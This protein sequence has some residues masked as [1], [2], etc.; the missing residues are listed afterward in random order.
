[1]KP[2]SPAPSPMVWCGVTVRSDAPRQQRGWTKGQSIWRPHSRAFPTRH[3]CPLSRR[4]IFQTLETCLNLTHLAV[5][6]AVY[7]GKLTLDYSSLT[8]GNEFT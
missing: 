5:R 3:A 7:I 4:Y 6:M 2:F 8:R 1:M